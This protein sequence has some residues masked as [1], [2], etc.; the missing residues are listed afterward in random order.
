MKASKAIDGLKWKKCDF[1]IHTPASQDDY[2][3]KQSNIRG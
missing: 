2:Q 1:H 3:S